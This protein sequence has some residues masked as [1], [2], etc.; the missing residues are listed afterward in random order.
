MSRHKATGLCIFGGDL[1]AP[2]AAEFG[3]LTVSV[4]CLRAA[5]LKRGCT[6]KPPGELSRPSAQ[7]TPSDLLNQNIWGWETGIRAF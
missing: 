1:L 2:G 3:V 4:T 5:E 7:A 6:L